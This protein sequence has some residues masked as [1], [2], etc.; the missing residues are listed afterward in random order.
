[1]SRKRNLTDKQHEVI[2]AL[3][4]HDGDEAAVL[5]RCGVPATR[6]Q[7]WLR[8]DAFRNEL[9]ARLK[10]VQRHSHLVLALYA[11]DAAAKLVDLTRGDKEE[12]VRKACLD[13]LDLAR[14]TGAIWD[15]SAADGPAT[16]P[17]QAPDGLFPGAPGPAGG[18]PSRT[19]PAGAPAG[20]A[21]APAGLPPE[22]YSHILQVLA[23]VAAGKIVAK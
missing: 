18:F 8:E 16:D 1:M 2:H 22:V 13:I 15:E 6:Y 23:D 14:R 4:T 12:T 20:C 7:K 19:G 5:E 17:E 11:P 21:Q 3:F 10:S 9:H